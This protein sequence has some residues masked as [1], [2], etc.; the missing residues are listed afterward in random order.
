MPQLLAAGPVPARAEAEA[1]AAGLGFAT[2]RAV[3]KKLRVES[4]KVTP[5]GRQ[6][7]EWVWPDDGLPPLGPIF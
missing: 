6:E 5:D 1:E 7:W 2:L 4:R 3:K